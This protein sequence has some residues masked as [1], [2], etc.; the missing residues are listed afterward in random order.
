MASKGPHA[1]GRR[2]G[3][4][5]V[6]QAAQDSL[7]NSV[8]GVCAITNIEW[9]STHNVLLIPVFCFLV[10]SFAVLYD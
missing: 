5:W 3:T 6:Q 8:G 4:V 7:K 2:E 9:Y 1:S 10:V